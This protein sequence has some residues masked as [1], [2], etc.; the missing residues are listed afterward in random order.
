M[1]LEDAIDLGLKVYLLFKE[2]IVFF[3][4][5]LLLKLWILHHHHLR[6]VFN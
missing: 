5:S 1:S 3:L 6:K 2:E 4:N